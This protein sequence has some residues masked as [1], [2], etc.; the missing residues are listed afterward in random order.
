MVKR[1]LVKTVGILAVSVMACLSFGS[2]M[3]VQAQTG[4][5]ANQD[6]GGHGNKYGKL[7]STSHEQRLAAAANKAAL[8][9][10]V[11]AKRNATGTKVPNA[12]RDTGSK[13]TS[14]HTPDTTK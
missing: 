12:A 13:A 5:G 10:K 3:N 9:E 8:M 11:K 14:I 4:P 1:R 7:R 6:V 2:G